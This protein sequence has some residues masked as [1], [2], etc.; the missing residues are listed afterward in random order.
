MNALTTLLLAAE[1]GTENGFWL[2][3][4]MGK[5]WWGT[6]AFLIVMLLVWKFGH[7]PVRDGLAR[8]T[9]RIA[10]TL[11][12]AAAAREA[13]EAERDRIKAALADSDAEAARILEEGRRAADV[14]ATEVGERAEQD[15]VSI[16]E[17]ATIDLAATRGQVEADLGGE[18]SRLAFGAA[19]KVVEDTLD[20]ANQQRLIDAYISQ[21]GSRN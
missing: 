18:L 2:P 14:M 8:R 15:L 19:E 10:T 9:E 21:V 5:V 13:A 3:Y 12:E 7:Q 6:P 11:G 1:P 16:R 17:R 4:D 20:D